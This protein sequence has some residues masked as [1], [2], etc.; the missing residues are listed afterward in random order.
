MIELICPTCRHEL[1][2]VDELPDTTVVFRC[3]DGCGASYI[4]QLVRLATENQL[5]TVDELIYHSGVDDG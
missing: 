1:V 3:V 4:M 2:I 5:P